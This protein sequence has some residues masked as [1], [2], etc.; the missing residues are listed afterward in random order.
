QKGPVPEESYEITFGRAAV[1]RDGKDVT[2][3]ALARMVHRAL[4]AADVLA[5][6]G[7]SVEVIDPRTVAP[8]D[9]ETIGQSV[10][11]T[12]RLLIADEAFAPFGIGAEIA[13]Q[14]ADRFFDELDAPIRRVNGVHT[15]TPYSP[16]LEAAVVPTNDDLIRAVRDLLAE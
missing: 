16:P 15:P 10:A 3:V 1:V 14:I 5:R 7:V 4:E 13:A 2:V 11:K 6:E 8:L 9:V 12:G